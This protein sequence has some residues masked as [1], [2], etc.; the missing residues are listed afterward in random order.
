MDIFSWNLSVE[1]CGRT[2]L[3]L[4]APK[5]M[6]FYLSLVCVLLTQH[7]YD[8]IL[9]QSVVGDPFGNCRDTER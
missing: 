3:S 2:C 5:R 4:L 7:V 6:L 1:Y 8:A 9:I